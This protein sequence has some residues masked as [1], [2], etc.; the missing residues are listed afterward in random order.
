MYYVCTKTLLCWY[1]KTSV[2]NWSQQ[3]KRSNTFV[4]IGALRLVQN[5]QIGIKLQSNAVKS[6]TCPGGCAELSKHTSPLQSVK[7]THAS[8]KL[9]KGVT[10]PAASDQR[11]NSSDIQADSVTDGMKRWQKCERTASMKQMG[12]KCGNEEAKHTLTQRPATS[13]AYTDTNTPH[14]VIQR[15]CVAGKEGREMEG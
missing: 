10:C 7:R 5:V 1:E 4:T 14:R 13:S 15:G 2:Q 12:V 3:C 8:A 9:V 11:N 6:A